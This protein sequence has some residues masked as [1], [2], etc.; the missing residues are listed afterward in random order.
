MSTAL[1]L[2]CKQW[3]HT[4]IA[5]LYREIILWDQKS[6]FALLSTIT[7]TKTTT[8]EHLGNFV[9]KV[10]LTGIAF[11]AEEERSEGY[12]VVYDRPSPE[13]LEACRKIVELCPNLV[14]LS[15]SMGQRFYPIPLEDFLMLLSPGVCSRVMELEV[16]DCH[17]W[18][19]DDLHPFAETLE[20]I[21][22]HLKEGPVGLKLSSSLHTPRLRTLHCLGAAGGFT[23]RGQWK[24]PR[25]ERLTLSFHRRATEGW[26][27]V[28]Q[29]H[30]AGLRYLCLA[31]SAD[32]TGPTPVHPV[33]PDS[34]FHAAPNLEHLAVDVIFSPS[35]EI[36]SRHP[37][38]WLDVWS[39]TSDTQEWFDGLLELEGKGVH[40]RC[41]DMA[42]ITSLGPDIAHII[43]PHPPKKRREY[44]YLGVDILQSGRDVRSR[45][46]NQAKGQDFDV[47]LEA[48]L[49]SDEEWNAPDSEEEPQIEYDS[50][51]TSE[52]TQSDG[53]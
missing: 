3:Y 40:V 12:I 24:M 51:Y 21:S 30:G 49:Q 4:G 52:G 27:D 18:S 11:G 1:V 47:D 23:P 8:S 10:T 37:L 35:F 38:R 33:P 43:S 28:I 50:S 26:T 46:D 32:P 7:A 13:N 29:Q 16:G 42:L 20:T 19:L 17:V 14:S 41:F 45:W 6:A 36:P 44:K 9:K 22:L 5:L 25:L 53:E 34:L 39:S 31:M 15:I 48:E 2:V